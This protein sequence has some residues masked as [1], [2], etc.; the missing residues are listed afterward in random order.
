[1]AA[2]KARKILTTG[3]PAARNGGGIIIGIF[4]GLMLGA[5]L[6]TAA[7]W[8]LTSASPFQLPQKKTPAQ[9]KNPTPRALAGNSGDKA[10]NK[11]DFEFYRMLPQGSDAAAARSGSQVASVSPQAGSTAA[12]RANEQLFLQVGAFANPSEADNMKALLALNGIEAATQQA[13]LDDGRVVHRVRVGPFASQEA[14]NPVRAQL[15]AAGV[16]ASVIRVKP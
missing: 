13:R 15:T 11:Q 6:A 4:I 7:A 16:T 14:L 3:K 5:L 10:G 12:A 8:Y 9:V 2:G 1:M